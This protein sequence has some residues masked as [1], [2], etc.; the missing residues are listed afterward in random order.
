[1]H[2][3]ALVWLGI[4]IATDLVALAVLAERAV[5]TSPPITCRRGLLLSPCCSRE[6]ARR[7]LSDRFRVGR[8][9]DYRFLSLHAGLP[10]CFGQKVQ[11]QP[12]S[13]IGGF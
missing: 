9:E 2:S 3:D 8:D 13:E 11:V 4:G 7:P 5:F 10:S 6:Q 1:M 12:T